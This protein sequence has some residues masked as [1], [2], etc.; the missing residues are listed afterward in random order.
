[1]ALIVHGR[2]VCSARRPACSV[3]VL[4][5]RCAFALA[6]RERRDALNVLR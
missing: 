1:M 6:H 2:T 4:R 5:E 3:C